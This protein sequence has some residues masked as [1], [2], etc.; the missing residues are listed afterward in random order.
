[1]RGEFSKKGFVWACIGAAVG[2]GNALRFPGLCARYGGGAFLAVYILALAVLGV[3]VLNSEIALGRKIRGG[4]PECMGSLCRFGGKL[5]TA[6]C[7]NSVFTAG[8]YA[9]LAGWLLAEGGCIIK[10]CAAGT[11]GADAAHYFFDGVL[12]CGG[13]GGLSKINPYVLI[14]IFLACAAV[15][16]CLKGGAD[17]L[18]K[19]ARFCVAAPV[20]FLAA[21]AVRGLA[22]PTAKQAVLALFVPDFKALL[23]AELWINALGQV[24]FSLSLAVGIMPAFGA[25]LPENYNIFPASLIIAAADALVSVLAS[26]ALFTALYGCGLQEGISSSGIITAFTVYPAAILG[27]FENRALC[28][29]FGLLFY[30]SLAMMAVQS[31]S[32]MAEAFLLPY[33]GRTGAGRKR[34]ALVICLFM[35]A[36]GVIYATDAADVA[37]KICDRYV[38]FYN[39]IALCLAEILILGHG[40]GAGGLI[41]EI[42]RYASKIKMPERAYR[43]CIKFLCPAVLVLFALPQ[44]AKFFVC[45]EPHWAVFAFGLL[46][47]AAVLFAGPLTEIAQKWAAARIK[48]PHRRVRNI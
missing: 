32:S 28:A 27:L 1:M 23:S 20:I 6:Q 19:A 42:N 37:V 3:P 17:S 39:V 31:A 12:R 5:G 10:L 16:F 33:T 22:Y 38:N 13:D 47:C 18:Q 9:G 14:C 30:I 44:F 7:L 48:K 40:R 25:R 4:A 26:V 15:Y 34:A 43:V 21:L 35:A 11:G 36:W 45:A 41:K 46:P 2:L 24:F 8:L 29:A